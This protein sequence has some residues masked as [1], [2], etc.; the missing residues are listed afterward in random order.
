M[1]D[2][3]NK[4]FKL[5]DIRDSEK[6]IEN[7]KRIQSKCYNPVLDGYKMNDSENIVNIYNFIEYLFQSKEEVVVFAFDAISFSI[8]FPPIYIN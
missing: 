2:D 6:I 7:Y 1:K 4:I 8:P 3:K 5:F